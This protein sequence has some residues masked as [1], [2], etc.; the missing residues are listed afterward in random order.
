MTE[1]DRAALSQQLSQIL[2]GS[3]A[4]DLLGSV[5]RS[6]RHKAG[7]TVSAAE[8]D[9]MSSHPVIGQCDS[10]TSTQSNQR[11]TRQAGK[12]A[13]PVALRQ[14]DTTKEAPAVGRPR[15]QSTK[16]QGQDGGDLLARRLAEGTRM[17]ETTTT[18]VT[19][20]LP[21]ELND[22][23]DEYVHRAWPERVR[24]QE[25]VIEGLRMLFT[26]RGRPGEPILPTT[27]LPAEAP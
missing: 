18:T 2:G 19:F 26:R 1:R 11:T 15:R 8:D 24:K 7:R 10:M 13:R 9:T 16:N 14:T 6:D 20:R 3:E 25:L 12:Q 4:T 5:I 22:W 21:K 27:L 23:L 17:A